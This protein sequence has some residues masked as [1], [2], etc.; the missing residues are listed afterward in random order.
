ME[1]FTLPDG[2]KVA[3]GCRIPI[4]NR[5]SAFPVYAESGPVFTRD[6]L[7]ALGKTRICRGSTKFDSSFIKN[8]RTKSSCNGF[9]GAAALTRAHIRRGLR[10]PDASGKYP[11][12]TFLSGAYL[13]SLINGNRDQGSLL[14]DGMRTLTEK[15]CATEQTVPWDKIFR[16]DYD[17]KKADA[18]AE[19]NR[20]FECYSIPPTSDF[21]VM[22]FSGLAAGFDAVVAVHADDAFMTLDGRGVAMGGN[23]P[24][25]HAVMCD[26]F[27]TDE[28][29]NELIGD[30]VNSWGLSYGMSGRMGL[31]QRQH[32]RHTMKYH[33]FYL[34]RSSVDGDT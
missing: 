34:I 7:I 25:N 26:G 12:E 18:E 11:P 33:Q 21:E 1:R 23:G 31:T 3:T 24:G 2:T 16:S 17:R 14:E 19:H 8:Q 28:N 20:A 32:F 5:V 6:E 30:G 4:S 15:G 27:W 13:Y 29:T 9:A 10:K 22:L